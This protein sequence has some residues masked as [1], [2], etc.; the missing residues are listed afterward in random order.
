MLDIIR[1][2]LFARN[3]MAR[4]DYEG[5]FA[6]KYAWRGLK[7]RSLIVLNQR[8]IGLPFEHASSHSNWIFDCIFGRD[9]DL[10]E[11]AYGAVQ[12]LFWQFGWEDAMAS[13]V[14]ADLRTLLAGQHP[15]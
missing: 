15:D 5:D 13:S 2:L 7:D 3:L 11:V 4:F 1:P 9:A 10:F 8:R 6:V 12:S 14:P